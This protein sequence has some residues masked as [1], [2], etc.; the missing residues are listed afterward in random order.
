MR[1]VLRWPGNFLHFLYLLLVGIVCGLIYLF[2][3]IGT[4]LFIW[5][6][7]GRARAVGKLRGWVLRQ[8]MST[9]GATFVKMGQ[10]MSTRP[11]IFA[12]EVIAQLRQL[13]DRMPPFGFWR[14][15]RIVEADLGPIADRFSEL[16]ERPVAAASV[17]QVHRARLKD[18][19]EVAVKVL[20]PA[21]RRQVERDAVILLGFARLIALHPKLR[22]SDP[23]GHL[24]EFVDAIHDQTDL[25]IEAA[26]YTRFRKNFTGWTRATFPEVFEE[27]SSGRVL[28]MAFIRGTKVDALPAGNHAELA[29]TVRLVMFKMCFDDGFMHADLHPGNM[30]VV[31][32][33]QLVIFDVGLAK[34]LGE[35]VLMQFI[36]MSKCMAMGTPDDLVAHLRRFHVYL[37]GVDWAAIRRDV[38]EFAERFRG[39]DTKTL[40]YGKLF[41]EMFAIGR[42]YRVQPVT[43]MAMVL[44]ALITAQGIGKML[45]PDDNAFADLARYLIPVLM[46]RNEKVPESE[47]ARA[48]QSA[49]P[50]ALAQ[51]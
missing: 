1:S 6:R 41:N 22:L 8:G 44:V 26:N 18:G 31:E 47:A 45:N 4:L 2:A 14:V 32:S 34:L 39:Q 16:D 20:R 27:H 50:A 15:R 12:P 51:A 43:D 49:Q 42:R 48:A 30:M 25:R 36:D 23:I 13:Q 37:D 28:T 9:A 10:V 46:R 33:G 38:G 24:R 40:D 29:E 7:A 35:D 5:N 17:A 19:R 21:V 3:R 11:D